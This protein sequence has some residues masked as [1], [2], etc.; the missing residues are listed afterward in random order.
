MVKNINVN[1]DVDENKLAEL[2]RYIDL[3]KEL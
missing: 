1:W 3:L 2:I